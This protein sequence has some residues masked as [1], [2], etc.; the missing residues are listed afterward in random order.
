MTETCEAIVLGRRNF[1]E[2]S[3]ILTLFTRELGRVDCLA[4]GCRRASSQMRGHFDLFNREEVLLWPR[5]RNGLDLAT[6]SLI[7]TEYMRLRKDFRAFAAAALAGEILSIACQK[8]DPHE[9]AYDVF[10]NY[11]EE[12]NRGGDVIFL[13]LKFLLEVLPPLGY[14]P[15]LHNCANCGK[16]LK[17]E[18]KTQ[19]S[20]KDGGLICAGCAGGAGKFLPQEATRMLREI[21]S[22]EQSAADKKMPKRLLMAL[23][24]YI[25]YNLA[26]ELRSA[27]VFSRLAG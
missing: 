18:E 15:Q 13:A 14:A 23:L 5:P 24:D 6:D 8:H 4:K 10:L 21:S 20:G 25:Q 3:L 1:S 17:A 16:E 12:L 19:L 9:N 7:V 27:K 26:R 11:L 2:T 22:P